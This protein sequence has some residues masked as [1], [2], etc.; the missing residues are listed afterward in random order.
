MRRLVFGSLSFWL[1]AS[2]S[3]PALHAEAPSDNPSD[4]P[5]LDTQSYPANLPTLEAPSSNGKITP[6][7][8]VKL[9]YQGF[10]QEQGIPSGDS[11]LTAYQAGTI[12]A[13]DLV[14][15][16]IA[17]QRLPSNVLNEPGYIAAVDSQLNGLTSGNNKR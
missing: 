10:L 16:A 15:G 4:S 1:L 5:N 17:A 7:N 2:M 13:E 9:A 14:K 3:A 8:L 6:F 11:V 12:T